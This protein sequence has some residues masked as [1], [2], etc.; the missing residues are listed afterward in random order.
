M[1]SMTNLSVLGKRISSIDQVLL[2]LESSVSTG[3]SQA[4]CLVIFSLLLTHIEDEL[5]HA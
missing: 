3:K 5:G 4:C 1:P 2:R